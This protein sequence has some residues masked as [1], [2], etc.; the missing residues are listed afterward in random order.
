MKLD[1]PLV[2]AATA[3]IATISDPDERHK[4][5]SVL[6]CYVGYISLSQE[7]PSMN[8]RARELRKVIVAFVANGHTPAA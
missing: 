2:N 8:A 7:D 1:Q 3:K 5:R 6:A 4:W